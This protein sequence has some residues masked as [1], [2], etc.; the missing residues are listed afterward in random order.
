MG[1]DVYLKVDDKFI[2]FPSKK[3]PDHLFRVGYFRSSYN[4]SG[5]NYVL[6]SRGLPTLW[7]V[8]DAKPGEFVPDW[9]KSL[10]RANHLLTDLKRSFEE[11]PY[12]VLSIGHSPWDSEVKDLGKVLTVFKQQKER[13]PSFDRFFSRVGFFSL[14]EPIQVHAIIPSDRTVYIV[15]P[16][17]QEQIDY[18]VQALEIVVETIE[19]VLSKETPAPSLHKLH[20]S[21]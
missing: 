17:T 9:E 3:Y 20:W 2:E 13:K 14:N 7:D 5:I 6:E 12:T 18:Y 16:I 8:F 1:L 15:T 19:Y 10:E 11:L 21:S 4:E